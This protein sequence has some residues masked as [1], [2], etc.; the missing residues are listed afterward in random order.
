MKPEYSDFKDSQSL[1]ARHNFK[2]GKIKLGQLVKKTNPRSF[3]KRISKPSYN[4]VISPMLIDDHTG[5]NFSNNLSQ[6]TKSSPDR[7][8]ILKSKLRSNEAGSEKR[9]VNRFLAR[10]FKNDSSV[11]NFTQNINNGDIDGSKLL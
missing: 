9:G 8:R 4:D 1:V 2:D 6:D 11:T 5:T 7:L 3:I 10:K